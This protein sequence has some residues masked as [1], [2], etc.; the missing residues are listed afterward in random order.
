MTG[1]HSEDLRTERQEVSE[2]PIRWLKT[3][4]VIIDAKFDLSVARIM[5]YFAFL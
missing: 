1:R 2:V 4:S 3:L 5:G